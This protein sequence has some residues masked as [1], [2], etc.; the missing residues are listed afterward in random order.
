MSE[1]YGTS[2]AALTGPAIPE[3]TASYEEAVH[4]DR[5]TSHVELRNNLS[6]GVHQ[7]FYSS[8]TSRQSRVANNNNPCQYTAESATIDP[9]RGSGRGRRPGRGSSGRTSNS[10]RGRHAGR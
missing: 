2:I 6:P 5:L 9:D 10:N 1:R 4:T 8:N 3:P 7:G